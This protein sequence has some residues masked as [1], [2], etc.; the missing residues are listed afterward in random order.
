MYRGIE[1]RRRHRLPVFSQ[2]GMGYSGGLSGKF[3]GFKQI[4]GRPFGA[5]GADFGRSCRHGWTRKVPV[6][7]KGPR[8][9][10]PHPPFAEMLGDSG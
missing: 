6:G 2:A 3:S 4:F 10:T 7:L 1:D 5:V 9:P 8:P